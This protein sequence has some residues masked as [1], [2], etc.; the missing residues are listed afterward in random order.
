MAVFT[1]NLRKQYEIKEV[2][3]SSSLKM[4]KIAEGY[5]DIHIKF[6]SIHEWDIAACHIILSES[7]GKLVSIKTQQPINYNRENL[8]IDPFIAISSDFNWL[9]YIPKD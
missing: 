4:C 3:M 6:N 5:A 2:A 1:K 8:K 9:E 7:G